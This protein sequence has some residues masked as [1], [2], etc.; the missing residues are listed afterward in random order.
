LATD[1]Y[2]KQ[3]EKEEVLLLLIFFGWGEST[4]LRGAASIWVPVGVAVNKLRR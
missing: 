4:E 1:F 3:E 2:Q